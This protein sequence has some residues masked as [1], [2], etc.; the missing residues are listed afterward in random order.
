MGKQITSKKLAKNV[1]VS[2]V[3][4][5]VSLLVS[6]VITLILPRYVGEYT[7]SYWQMYTMYV[8]Y[9]GVLHFGLLDG[10]ILRYG[11]YDFEELDQRRIRSQFTILFTITSLCMLA[12]L[13]AS[14]AFDS[15]SRTIFS[16]VAVGI[17]TKNLTTYNSDIF[18]ITNQINRYAVVNIAQRAIYGIFV[19]VLLINRV[20]VFYLYCLSDLMGDILGFA[21]GV[22]LNRGKLYFGKMIGLRDAWREAGQN[23]SAG[24]VLMLANWSSILLI[25]SARMI[26]EWRWGE[27]V[28]GK[29][30]FAFSLSNVFLTF[31]TA[32]SVVLFPSLKRVDEEKLPA[33]YEQLR[34]VMSLLMFAL[35]ILFFPGSWLVEL[36]LPNYAVSLEYLAVLL[37]IVVFSSKVN[38]LTN[39]YLKVYR[40]EK[41]MLVINLISVASGVVL[42][43]LCAYVFNNLYAL[44]GCVVF[45]MILNSVLSELAVGRLIGR[46]M[47]KDFLIE[48]VMTVAFILCASLLRTLWG[49]IAYAA[50]LAVYFLIK[51]RAIAD[52]FRMAS[53]RLHTKRGQGDPPAK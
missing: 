34:K 6:F 16:L 37:P 13:A 51:R 43:L 18:Q 49:M 8:A 44:L 27:L 33:M 15:T 28:F 17:V 26:T 3:A 50:V 46:R 47:G 9:V 25:G 5:V 30:S 32:I 23:F 4:Q 52:L 10:L 39:N 20:D 31:V 24:F 29:V 11:A 36:W 12:V 38:L 2:L 41:T 40:R 45:T 7:Y 19:V 21:L 14:C 1:F 53:H 35:L 42:A 48:I 22:V